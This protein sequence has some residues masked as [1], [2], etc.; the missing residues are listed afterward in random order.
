MLIGQG[1]AQSTNS[2][3]SGETPLV[4]VEIRE[5]AL[6]LPQA[7]SQSKKEQEKKE[8][9]E[10]RSQR[11]LGMPRFGTTDR[12]DARP[13][14]RAGKFQLFTKL[15]F[16]P[17][18]IVVVGAQAG[19]SQADNQYQGYGQGAAGYGRRFGAALGDHVSNTFFSD[20]LYPTLFKHDPRYFRLGRGGFRKRLGYS[21]LQVVECH[22]DSGGRAFNVSN[23][24]GALSSGGLSNA[25]YPEAD[26]GFKL[27]MKG[28]ALAVAYGGAG[29]LLSEFWPDVQRKFFKNK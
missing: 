27:T 4:G 2:R 22:T 21:L 11:V 19:L 28:S 6:T 8:E 15:A 13:L 12:M 23:V 5:S 29:N 3:S 17:V 9:Q 16:D 26:R 7:P 18:M 14:T 25:Y 20:F 24:L 10:E 1:Q